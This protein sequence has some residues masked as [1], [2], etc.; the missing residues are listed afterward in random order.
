MTPARDRDLCSEDGA[1]DI[2]RRLHVH[3]LA[4][5]VQIKTWVEILG[6]PGS[7]EAVYCVRSNIDARR[8]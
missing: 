5:G 6:K 2:R 7:A 3:Q 4:R 8:P 1:N